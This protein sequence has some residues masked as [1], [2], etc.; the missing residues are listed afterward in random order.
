MNMI[1]N[2]SDLKNDPRYQN[3]RSRLLLLNIDQLQRIIDSD[4]GICYDT[5]NYNEEFDQYCPIAKSLEIRESLQAL[6]FTPTDDLVRNMIRLYI[7]EDFSVAGVSGE[8][9][10]DNREADLKWLCQEIINEKTT[11]ATP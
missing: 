8:F 3:I 10:R 5:Y 7:G 2:R 1:N 11:A 9:Y 6:G 4:S